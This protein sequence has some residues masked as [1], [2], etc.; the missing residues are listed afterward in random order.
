MTNARLV[1]TTLIPIILI[2]S[3]SGCSSSED[4]V[5]ATPGPSLVCRARSDRADPRDGCYCVSAEEDAKPGAHH[6]GPTVPACNASYAGPKTT[7]CCRD[8]KVCQCVYIGCD[9]DSVTNTCTCGRGYGSAI[10][11]SM[12]EVSSCSLPPKGRCCASWAT[13]SC[14]CDASDD[15]CSTWQET[16]ESVQSCTAHTVSP[17][18]KSGEQEVTSC[19]GS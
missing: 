12:K 18:C 11:A 16:Y 7:I 9:T 14:S 4:D 15:T 1:L 5:A 10:L 19:G 13:S 8:S 17:R 2:A 3:L 6:S